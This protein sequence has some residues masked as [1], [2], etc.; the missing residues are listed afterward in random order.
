MKN[1]ETIRVNH[2]L[3]LKQQVEEMSDGLCSIGAGA[4][5]I[6]TSDPQESKIYILLAFEPDPVR[7]GIVFPKSVKGYNVRITGFEASTDRELTREELEELS[8]NK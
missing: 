5:G 2:L 6:G 3:L 4:G 8:Q 7:N 1:E